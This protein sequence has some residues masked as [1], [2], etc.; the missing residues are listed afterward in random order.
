MTFL[1][2]LRL[3]QQLIGVQRLQFAVVVGGL[4]ALDSLLPLGMYFTIDLLLQVLT[5]HGLAVLGNILLTIFECLLQ[6][7]FSTFILI[8]D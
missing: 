7:S 1:A 8:L 3:T 5:G 2:Q 6:L 4:F